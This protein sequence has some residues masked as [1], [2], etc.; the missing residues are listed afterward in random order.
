[1]VAETFRSIQGESTYAGLP[2]FFVRLAGC[3]LACKYCDTQYARKIQ[4]SGHE[5]HTVE[6]IISSK[7]PNDK[8]VCITGGEPLLQEGSLIL[9]DRLVKKGCTVLLETNGSLDISSVPKEVI[10]IMDIKCPG[11]GMEHQNR[12]ENLKFLT[13]QDQLKF[14]ITSRE[15]FEFAACIVDK[16]KL[17]R[18]ETP[19]PTDQTDDSPH[20][21]PNNNPHHNSNNSPHIIVS[22][23]SPFCSPEEPAKWLL[24]SG[25]SW[26]LQLQLHKIIWPKRERGV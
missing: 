26:R 1:M 14:V 24:E 18:A 3:N 9:M 23:A 4:A 16:H 10:K 25:R 20:H 8:L 17:N 11:S 5:Q 15:D 21:K 12:Y 7:N 6:S 2:C 13:N 19:G 22:P